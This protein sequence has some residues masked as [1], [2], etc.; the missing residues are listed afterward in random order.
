MATAIVDM[1]DIAKNITI[2]VRIKGIKGFQ[3]RLWLTKWILRLAVLVSRFKISF[4][5]WGNK[6]DIQG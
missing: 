1:A 6:A 4:E 5:G 2:T 3:A